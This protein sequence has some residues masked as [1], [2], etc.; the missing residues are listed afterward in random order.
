MQRYKQTRFSRPGERN[1]VKPYGH[2]VSTFDGT[3]SL[4]SAV[5]RSNGMKPRVFWLHPTKGY[6]SRGAR[7]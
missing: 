4:L 5:K 1:T 6:R 2:E 7:S 3:V